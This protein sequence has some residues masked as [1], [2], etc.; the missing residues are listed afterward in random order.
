MSSINKI[1]YIGAGLDIKVVK[2][3]PKTSTFV[4]VD[5]EPRCTHFEN[6][7]NPIF[8]KQMYN[9]KF[10]NLLISTCKELGFVLDSSHEM[11]PKYYKKI[12]STF[13]YYFLSWF[14]PLPTNINPTMLVFFNKETSQKIIYYMST[15]ILLNMNSYLEHDIHSSDGIIVSGYHPHSK[16]LDY[17]KHPKT[18]L[19]YTCTCYGKFMF[20]D[21]EDSYTII[22]FLHNCP[23]NTIYYFNDFYMIDRENGELTKCENFKDFCTKVNSKSNLTKRSFQDF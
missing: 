5:V 17:F 1:L 9:S 7:I 6:D 21:M 8:N 12:V 16:L 13:R 18:F 23:C 4:F 14:Y 15:N 2:H 19:G 20:N 11:D 22:S 3:F 10:E